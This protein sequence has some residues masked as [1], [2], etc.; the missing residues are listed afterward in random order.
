MDLQEVHASLKTV[1]VCLLTQIPGSHE[2][3]VRA[4]LA[5]AIT[6]K[7]EGGLGF[8][9][10]VVNFRGCKSIRITSPATNYSYISQARVFLS[11]VPSC[12]LQDTL[13]ITVLQYCT[14]GQGTQKR[15]S[16]A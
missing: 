5:P 10:V 6:P 9:G 15:L 4:I 2:S 11:Q 7:S 13:K 16:W 12:I 14:L 3:Y 1:S 8:R